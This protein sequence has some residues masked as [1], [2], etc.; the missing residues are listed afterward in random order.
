MILEY[1]VPALAIATM[2][3]FIVVAWRIVSDT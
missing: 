1:G 2:I 3:T